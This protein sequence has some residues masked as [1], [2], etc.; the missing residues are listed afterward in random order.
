MG[1]FQCKHTKICGGIEARQAIYK[2]LILENK[3]FSSSDRCRVNDLS[4]FTPSGDS[5]PQFTISISY[6]TV[7]PIKI[8]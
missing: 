8:M 1:Q 5:E 7:R 6:D 4:Y 2:V 3:S